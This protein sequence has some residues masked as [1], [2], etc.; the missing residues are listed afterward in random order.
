[1]AI[2]LYLSPIVATCQ[3]YSQQFSHSTTINKHN[4]ARRIYKNELK[5]LGIYVNLLHKLKIIPTKWNKDRQRLELYK[6]RFF[7]YW[8]AFQMVM[9]AFDGIFKIIRTTEQS[10]DK[11]LGWLMKMNLWRYTLENVSINVASIFAH[12]NPSVLKFIVNNLISVVQRFHGKL[13][14]DEFAINFHNY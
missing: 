2:F 11:E 12:W 5:L 8:F 9:F 4:K 1:M 7:K 6:H 13:Y 10:G 14:K 3:H